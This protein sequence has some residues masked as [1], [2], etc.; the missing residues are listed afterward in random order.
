MRLAAALLLGA[1]LHAQ[2]LRPLHVSA[3]GTIVDD[4]GGPVVL[5][6]LN[7]SGTGSGNAEADAT[8]QEYAAQNQL[9][10]MNLVRLF[11]NAAWWTSNVKVPIANMAYQ[12]YIDSLVQRAKKYGN[13]VLVVKAGQFPDAPC[14]ADGKNCPAP[15]QGDLNCQANASLCAAQDTTGNNIDAAFTFWAAFAKKYAAD[16]AVLYD[17]WED[18]HGIDANT[19]SDGQN[20]LIAAI[21][22]YNPHALIF[23]EDTGTAFES[24]VAGTLPDFAWSDL[25]WNFHLYAGPTTGCA[26]PAASPRLSNWPRNFDPLV[27]YA[28]DHGHAAAI[29]EWGGCNDSEPYHTN[30]TSY[31]ALHAVA[32]AYFDS[33]NLIALSG[34]TWQLTPGGAKVAQAY[35]ALAAGASK[36]TLRSNTP[37]QDAINNRA[38]IVPGSW[39]AVYGTNFS[40]VTRDWSDQDFSNGL[41]TSVAGVQVLVNG[42][43]APVWYVFP[44]QVNFQAPGNLA[45][46]ATVAVVHN[47]VAGGAATVQVVSTSPG[48]ISYSKDFVT[49]YPS[50]QFAGTTA[51]VGDPAVFGSAVRKARPGDQIALYVTGLAPTDSGSVI[52]APIPF[53]AP[54]AINI[55]SNVVTP[56]FAAQIGV[57]YYQI[58]FTVPAGLAPANYPFTITV[59]GATSQNGVVLVV[60]P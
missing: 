18:M 56:S 8:E 29:A 59:N 33:S 43:P 41:P 57:G 39:V 55:G 20:L 27:N 2:S 14:G 44:G 54:I 10:S 47:G 28:Q 3:A 42:T 38:Q 45:G 50:A 32:L 12:D 46:T 1:M 19:W 52:T 16:P 53:S 26:E 15:N 25:V 58:N 4:R 11:V 24:I 6:G 17:T 36:P 13:Y 35:T 34:N 21:R 31:A 48:V 9:L 40:D 49:Y 5:R 7:R 23:V 30:I 60:G 51:I 22:T 37:V